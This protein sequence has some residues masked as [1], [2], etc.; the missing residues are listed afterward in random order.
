MASVVNEPESEPEPGRL[1][2]IAAK[3]LMKLFYAARLA[4]FDLLR[5]I[6]NLA[7]YI[8]KWTPE[9]DRRLHRLMCYVKSTTN[10]R[11]TGWVGDEMSGAN[12]HLYA[13][14]NYGGSCGR[15]TTG[16]QL[17][18]EG[19]KTSFP[20]EAVSSVQTAVSHSTPEAE[21]VAGNHAIR[22]I[23]MPTLIMWD[24]LKTCPDSSEVVK[25]ESSDACMAAVHT[26]PVSDEKES[27]PHPAPKPGGSELSFCA[28]GA[29]V[30]RKHQCSKATVKY[31]DQSNKLIGLKKKG[32]YCRSVRRAQCSP[33]SIRQ[34]L[35]NLH[36]LARRNSQSHREG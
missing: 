29:F 13:D 12:L 26:D 16:V 27:K 20:I 9:H 23:G 5:A 11:Q 14:A 21:I 17:N 7:R 32:L 15:S 24:R 4:R 30:K 18:V 34:S 25:V 19:P 28:A 35:R 33:R 3:I 31:Y 2:S 22:K 10:Y 6:A 36:T 1:K 8:T